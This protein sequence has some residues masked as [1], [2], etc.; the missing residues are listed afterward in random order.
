MTLKKYLNLMFITTLICWGVFVFVLK[1]V[2]PQITNG[3]GFV[4]FY[5]SLFLA[6]SGTAA[7]LGFFIRFWIL[8]QKLAFYT[9]KIAF[10]QAFLFGILIVSTLML[11]SRDLFSW[12][13]L[14][15]L[16]LI[17]TVLEFFLISYQANRKK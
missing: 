10:R 3:L 13:N 15:L 14:V 1:N 8:K 4:M 16:I 11:L 7:I 6:I 9:V 12:F 5:A 2:N 17:L